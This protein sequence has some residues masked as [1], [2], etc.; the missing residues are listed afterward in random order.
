[1]GTV[2]ALPHFQKDYG[3]FLYGKWIIPA[4]WLAL[5]HAF[6][7]I[8]S[9]I[10][11]V[12]AGWFQDRVGRRW[13]L[14]TGS[15]ISAIGVAILYVSNLPA[16][17]DARR[18]VFLAGKTLQGL[19]TGFVLATI[20][21]YISETV[22]IAMRGSALA[23][24]PTAIL[25]GQL[26]GSVVVFTSSSRDTSK[27][28]LI[29]IASQWPFSAVPFIM[30]LLMPES[31]AHLIRR[32]LMDA[33]WKASKRLYTNDI[34]AEVYRLKASIEHERL[35]AAEA[36][37]IACF[38]GSNL[39][40]TGIVVFTGMIPMLFGLP[41]LSQ[42]SYFMQVVGMSASNSLIFLIL[43]IALGLIGNGIGVW[44]MSRVGRRISTFTSLAI[45]TVLWCAMGVAGCW[46]GV[47][48]IW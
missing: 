11:G 48:T 40:R 35:L 22:P 32:D 33:A 30:A 2:A 34:A 4:T 13:S 14:A 39:R 6:G 47:V 23:L 16:D 41:L 37:Y 20:Q 8:G 45:T 1:M 26:M 38:R 24:C 7:P 18:G 25:L 46:T 43:G 42:A 9:V 12:S 44:L 27:A 31:P 3:R 36:T 5:W 17:Y 15:L 21:T 28:Y 29:P 19:S 10:G